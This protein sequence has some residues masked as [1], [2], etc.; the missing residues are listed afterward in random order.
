MKSASNSLGQTLAPKELVCRL[1]RIVSFPFVA[2]S[3][4]EL[5]ILAEGTT[6]KIYF[7]V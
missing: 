6:S 4:F 1:D 7:I 5:S 3:N 2:S